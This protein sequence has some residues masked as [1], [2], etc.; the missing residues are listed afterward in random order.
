MQDKKESCRGNRKLAQ[1]DYHLKKR[2]PVTKSRKQYL[3]IALEKMEDRRE[4]RMQTLTEGAIMT[5]LVS[6]QSLLKVPLSWPA[7]EGSLTFVNEEGQALERVKGIEPTSL[8]Q[9]PRPPV[10]SKYFLSSVASFSFS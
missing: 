6:H 3:S 5:V 9:K 2:K 4:E 8:R 1:E 7:W 10:R